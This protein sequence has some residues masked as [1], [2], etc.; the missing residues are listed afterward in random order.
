MTW[1]EKKHTECRLCGGPLDKVFDF[2]PMPLANAL[3]DNREDALKAP[4][5]EQK[6][7][8][9]S[10]CFLGQLSNVINPEVLYKD[11]AYR[12]STSATFREH[13]A[14][15]A[16]QLPRGPLTIVDIAGNDGAM[17]REI[18][19]LREDVEVFVIDPSQD[20][21]PEDYEKI[22]KFWNRQTAEDFL[23][24]KWAADVVIAQ[25]V[26]G[27]V[28][29]ILG[30]FQAVRLAID[31]A[32]GVFI[33]EVPD[34]VELVKRGAFE[35]IYHEHVSYWT[36]TAMQ[37]LAARTGFY[38]SSVEHVPIHCGSLRF[39][40]R[41]CDEPRAFRWQPDHEFFGTG[42]LAKFPEVSRD[43]LETF[44]RLTWYN[45]FLARALPLVHG[46]FIIGVTA[47]AKSSVFL[48]AAENLGIKDCIHYLV[49]SAHSKHGKFTPR[50]GLEVKPFT[51]VNVRTVPVAVLFARNI[52]G[53]LT[54]ALVKNGFRGVTLGV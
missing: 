40:L 3:Y 10:K 27:H 39:W 2:G 31:P 51:E 35:T 49:D 21:E 26:V 37:E 11:Y 48:N 53:E 16:R 45:P 34:F 52:A 29:E 38:I 46:S 50:L 24:D 41:P 33:V 1:T 42:I 9:C 54:D 14:G 18:L 15:L 8:F 23:M 43:R 32:T 12:S 28:D 17:A 44:S 20:A 6:L 13:C 47:S 19:A 22:K 30:F 5:F 7:L 4:V 25:N 36:I